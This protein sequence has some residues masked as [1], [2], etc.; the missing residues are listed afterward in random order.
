MQEFGYGAIPAMQHLGPKACHAGLVLLAIWREP[1][2]ASGPAVVS[3]AHAEVIVG[4]VV[5]AAIVAVVVGVLIGRRTGRRP[6]EERLASLGARLGIDLEDFPGKGGVEPAL[7]RLE[8][9]TGQAAEVVAESS[10]ESMR[11]KRAL[12]AMNQGIIIC[13]VNG[14]VVFRNAGAVRMMSGRHAE[15]I[16]AQAVVDLL[17]E[18]WDKGEEE[19][20]IDL[21]GPPRRSLTL[22][23]RVMGDGRKSIGVAAIIEDVTERKR[24]D[25]IR[26]DFVSNVSHELK[27]PIG[28]LGLLVE[29]LVDET[30]PA[31]GKRLAARV[32][33]EAFR[34]NRILEDLLDLSRIEAQESPVRE[35]VPVELIVAEALDRVRSAADQRGVTLDIPRVDDSLTVLGDRRQLVSAVYNLVD[36]AVKFSGEGQSVRVEC[37]AAPAPH[38]GGGRPG[39]T[40]AGNGSSGGGAG[41]GDSDAMGENTAA[42]GN[43]SGDETHTSGPTGT[44]YI[45]GVV[46]ASGSREVAGEGG[47]EVSITVIDNGVGIPSRDLD[48][49]FERFYRVD[50]ARSHKA[51]GTGLGLSIV[52]HVASNHQGRV[53]VESREGE[54]SI[55]RL[56][57][58]GGDSQDGPPTTAGGLP[59]ASGAGPPPSTPS[60]EPAEANARHLQRPQDDGTPG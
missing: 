38:G 24:V 10:E 23:A 29:T 42:D 28:A 25:E 56:V 43:G 33:S 32:Q 49:I 7:H 26:R 55:F 11:F 52:R 14:N 39:Y 35:P 54:G 36:N 19:R 58:P 51:G 45:R 30:D 34:V 59:P 21:Y 4:V 48:R 1:G 31:I 20:E 2:W 46:P 60:D 9:V 3:A 5:A 8:Q 47:Q 17:N 37:T 13:D 53:E 16:V 6:I 40:T 22:R 18:A 27:T 57:L 12:D 15:A 44:P 41:G 50:I